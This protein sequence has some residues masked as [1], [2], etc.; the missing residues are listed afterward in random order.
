MDCD[1]VITQ[2]EFIDQDYDNFLK[3]LD[4]DSGYGTVEDYK[5]CKDHVIE[6]KARVKVLIN[7]FK[8]LKANS[9]WFK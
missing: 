6:A 9:V 1:K 5:Q 3:F 8:S 2:L 7:M 4:M